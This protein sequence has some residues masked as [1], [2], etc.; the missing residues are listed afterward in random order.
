MFT[1][2][3]TLGI[4]DWSVASPFL[5]LDGHFSQM[6]LPFLN[7]VND[8]S[9]KWCVCIGVLYATHIW[10][11]ADASSLNGS[12]KIELTKVK[13]KYVQ[14]REVPKFEPMD[15]VPLVNQAFWKS[16]RSN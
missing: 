14:H 6:M 15:I 13:R 1:Y 10:Q 12:F 16:F 8:P 2:L 5:L 4:Y 3:D 11:V 7:Y 9:H